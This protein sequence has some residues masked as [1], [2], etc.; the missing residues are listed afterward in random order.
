[1]ARLFPEFASQPHVGARY[2]YVYSELLRM[3]T[4][5]T[6]CLTDCMLLKGWEKRRAQ[7]IVGIVGDCILGYRIVKEVQKSVR[8]D[9]VLR[10]YEVRLRSIPWLKQIDEPLKD[11]STYTRYEEVE[12]ANIRFQVQAE[13]R[14]DGLTYDGALRGG[15]EVHTDAG[16]FKKIWIERDASEGDFP[17]DEA[18]WALKYQGKGI[19]RAPNTWLQRK[20]WKLEEVPRDEKPK[21]KRGRPPKAKATPA[22][23]APSIEVSVD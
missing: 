9:R 5:K 8:V 1:M 21:K 11:G 2:A 16:Q 12:N 13:D 17:I 10:D 6:L 20:T 22:E 4:A 3:A 23:E 18:W 15:L 19:A 7:A 14:D